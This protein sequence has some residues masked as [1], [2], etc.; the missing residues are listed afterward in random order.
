MNEFLRKVLQRMIDTPGLILKWKLLQR[1]N[2]CNRFVDTAGKL[3]DMFIYEHIL[4]I[5]VS[6]NFN[7]IFLG[8]NSPKILLTDCTF[9]FSLIRSTKCTGNS[10]FFVLDKTRS[11]HNSLTEYS[12]LE[13]CSLFELAILSR[14][15]FLVHMRRNIFTFVFHH[16]FESFTVFFIHWLFQFRQQIFHRFFELFLL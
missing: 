2:I 3:I 13:R 7:S 16:G 8:G 10:I 12:S 9:R 1:R 6:L 4:I 15:T 11:S 5:N 14:T